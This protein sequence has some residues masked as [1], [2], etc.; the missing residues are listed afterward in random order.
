MPESATG[1]YIAPGRVK[2]PRQPRRR[3]PVP[4]AQGGRPM[5]AMRNSVLA[6]P[7][8]RLGPSLSSMPARP[9]TPSAGLGANP[10]YVVGIPPEAMNRDSRTGMPSPVPTTQPVN[11]PG[12]LNFRN[13]IPFI[14]RSIR[15]GQDVIAEATQRAVNA[16]K[17]AA[18]RGV[19]TGVP[20]AAQGMNAGRDAAARAVAAGVPIAA[21]GM[22]A[23]RDAAVR[24]VGDGVLGAR[25]MAAGVGNYFNPPTANAGPPIQRVSPPLVLDPQ[26]Q[27]AP[28][29]PM[30]KEDQRQADLAAARQSLALADSLPATSSSVALPSSASTNL[31]EQN[32]FQASGADALANKISGMS[33]AGTPTPE[34]QDL[35][36]RGAAASAYLRPGGGLTEEYAAQAGGNNTMRDYTDPAQMLRPVGG[37]PTVESN[38]AAMER[39]GLGQGPNRAQSARSM[40][41]PGGMGSPASF[42]AMREADAAA[43][44]DFVMPTV[45]GAMNRDFRG[46]DPAV[47]D[48]IRAGDARRRERRGTPDPGTPQA[49]QLFRDQRQRRRDR[50]E[51]NMPIRQYR[52][53]MRNQQEVAPVTFGGQGTPFVNVA[54]R[55]N[56]GPGLNQRTLAATRMVRGDRLQDEQ[57]A[58]D[59]FTEDRTFRADNRYRNR[60]QANLE[61]RQLFQDQQLAF[62]REQAAETERHNRE[63]ERMETTGQISKQ[64]ADERQA[65]HNRKMEKKKLKRDMDDPTRELNRQ[66]AQDALDDNKEARTPSGKVVK[67]YRPQVVTADGRVQAGRDIIMDPDLSPEDKRSALHDLGLDQGT[68]LESLR[69]SDSYGTKYFTDETPEFHDRYNNYYEMFEGFDYGLPTP[70]QAA[71]V[72]A[73]PQ[74]NHM[75]ANTGGAHHLIRGFGTNQ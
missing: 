39:L 54:R 17:N 33:M 70:P 8:Q 69:Q 52:A 22:N 10:D 2:R 71:P 24:A 51:A 72:P 62:Q 4:P 29:R 44:A 27:T 26:V 32:A 55:F 53:L 15:R 37:R 66:A 34:Q 73:A 49:D 14:E 18:I 11:A 67:R 12:Q 36:N 46:M 40:M 3:L 60:Q 57:L 47:A 68:L 43:E 30:N 25:R 13:N 28:V 19:A 63:L 74:Q 56:Q 42:D 65:E 38:A 23:G 1:G 41:Q 9:R 35:M 75:R 7:T 21:Q 50:S 58:R 59:R 6:P 48:K 61:A 31:L 5:N 16:A 20:M 64:E 45:G